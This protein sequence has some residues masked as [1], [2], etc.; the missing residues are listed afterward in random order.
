MIKVA[1]KPSLY[2]QI[3]LEVNKFDVN[4]DCAFNNNVLKLYIR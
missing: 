2:S 4:Y 1:G 3:N